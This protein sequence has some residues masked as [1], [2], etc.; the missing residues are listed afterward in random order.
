M[1]HLSEPRMQA[2]MQ[3]ETEKENKQFHAQWGSEI[4]S[5]ATDLNIQALLNMQDQVGTALSRAILFWCVFVKV[6]VDQK[7]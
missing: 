2:D 4:L 6:R 3:K 1:N 7:L 5:N